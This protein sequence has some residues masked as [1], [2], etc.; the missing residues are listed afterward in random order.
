[1]F[2]A[3]GGERPCI[4]GQHGHA[5]WAVGSLQGQERFEEVLGFFEVFAVVMEPNEGGRHARSPGIVAPKW[6]VVTKTPERRG[7][8]QGAEKKV[9]LERAVSKRLHLERHRAS[10]ARSGRAKEK[11]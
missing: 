3:E 6:G 8:R 1:L 9:R 11:T 7:S 10:V 4:C 2:A 5:G